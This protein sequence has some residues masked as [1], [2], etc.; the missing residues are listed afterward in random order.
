MS[1]D[2]DLDV[3]RSELDASHDEHHNHP[4]MARES[5]WAPIDT[6]SVCERLDERLGDLADHGY[7]R[8]A[9]RAKETIALD[10]LGKEV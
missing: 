8:L 4:L 6:E 9:G 10:M 2:S 3:L 1:R 7:R 5:P